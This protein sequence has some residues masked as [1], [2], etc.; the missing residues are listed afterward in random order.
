AGGQRPNPAHGKNSNP[1]QRPAHLQPIL[2]ERRNLI[3]LRIMEPGPIHER[4]SNEMKAKDDGK[5]HSDNCE[6]CLEVTG[7]SPRCQRTETGKSEI[8]R[9][10]PPRRLTAKLLTLAE[11]QRDLRK[12]TSE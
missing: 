5:A 3:G 11:G 6:H 8:G 12:R 9:E 10:K 1:Q 4:P 2:A 7:F